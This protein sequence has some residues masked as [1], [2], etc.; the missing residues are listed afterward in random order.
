MA[1][2]AALIGTRCLRAVVEPVPVRVQMAVKQCILSLVILDAAACFVVHGL[3]GALI[4]LV[5]LV[6]TVV[7]GW[8][9]ETT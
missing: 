3:P 9:I 7:L 5:L 4:V 6:P 1:V 2:L 8:R